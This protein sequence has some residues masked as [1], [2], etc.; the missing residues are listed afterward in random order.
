MFFFE[1]MRYDRVESPL[2][3]PATSRLVKGFESSIESTHVAKGIFVATQQW[4][5]G[6]V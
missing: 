6:A 2:D 5:L 3:L 4:Y 1:L